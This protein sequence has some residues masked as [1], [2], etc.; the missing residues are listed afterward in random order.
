MFLGICQVILKEI[1]KNNSSFKISPPECDNLLSIYI[2]SGGDGRLPGPEIP[3]M[4]IVKGGLYRVDYIIEL[5]LLHRKAALRGCS[6]LSSAPCSEAASASQAPV[7]TF[8]P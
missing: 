7:S 2:S 1:I 8:F 5:K 4:A 3:S 6:G